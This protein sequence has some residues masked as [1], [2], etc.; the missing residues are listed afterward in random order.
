M[1]NILYNLK[2]YSVVV[3]VASAVL[4]VLL[5]AFPEQMLSYAA[6]FLG[7]A[8]IVCGAVAVINY[9]I[10]KNSKLALALGIIALIFGIII[11]ACHTQIMSAMIFIMGIFLLIGGLFDLVNSIEVAVA[12]HRSWVLTIIMSIASIVLGIVSVVNPFG[13]QRKVVILIGCGLL[14]FAVLECITYFQIKKVNDKIK[15]SENYNG[16]DNA[17]EVD[18]E[19]AD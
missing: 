8:I 19:D 5:I 3:M 14:L 18:F 17:K 10:K 4:G 16:E 13:V 2:K 7:G 9:F 11:C 1:K 6:Y 12:K 15:S